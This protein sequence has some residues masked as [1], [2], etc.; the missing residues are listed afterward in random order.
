MIRVKRVYEPA[1]EGDGLRCLVDRLW[2]RGLSRE[3]AGVDRWLKEAAPSPELRRWFA[4]D[5]ARWAEFRRRYS[6]EL[7]A[8][9]DAWQP[10]LEAARSGGVTL[11]Y[12]AREPVYNN[13]V[14]LKA[15]LEERL[16]RSPD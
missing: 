1:E 13:A 16:E 3:A 4:H 7:E 9:P 6:A 15:F 12:A 10:L 14:A 11:L 8:R 5:P 2:P